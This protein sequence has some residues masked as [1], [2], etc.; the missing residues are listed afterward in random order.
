MA[1]GTSKGD[2]SESLQ[3]TGQQ[4]GSIAQDAYGLFKEARD[5]KS[6]ENNNTDLHKEAPSQEEPPLDNSNVG[7]NNP[8]DNQPSPQSDFNSFR[9]QNDPSGANAGNHNPLGNNTNTG[10]SSGVNSFGR[11]QPPQS[12][13]AAIGANTA[14]AAADSSANGIAG[15]GAQAAKEGVN[16]GVNAAAQASEAAATAG[17]AGAAATSE[18]AAGAAGG[19]VGLVV[20]TAF[21]LRKP[22]FKGLC[23][24]LVIFL[25]IIATIIMGL[26]TVVTEAMLGINGKKPREYQ[27]SD[28]TEEIN[29]YYGEVANKLIDKLNKK[30]DQAISEISASL[31]SYGISVAPAT[32]SA[33]LADS[34]SNP[35]NVGENTRVIISDGSMYTNS[36]YDA[37][38]I[39][40]C[41]SASLQNY[42]YEYESQDDDDIDENFFEWLFN[43]N[44]EKEG[45]HYKDMLR[46]IGKNNI[47]V[48]PISGPQIYTQTYT[49]TVQKE[50]SENVQVS[51]T[52]YSAAR[53]SY[54]EYRAVQKKVYV[55]DS[56]YR[57]KTYY[58]KT[59]NII[60]VPQGSKHWVPNYYQASSFYEA[61]QGPNGKYWKVLADVSGLYEQGSGGRWVDGMS[62]S[63]SVETQTR[64]VE[65]E[66]ERTDTIYKYMINRLDDNAIYQA[67]GISKYQDYG[68]TTYQM[69]EVIADMQQN[70]FDA[71]G[72]VNG[73]FYYSTSTRADISMRIKSKYGVIWFILPSSSKLLDEL[74]DSD[75]PAE[76]KDNFY[77]G[78]YTHFPATVGLDF[79]RNNFIFVDTEYTYTH[80]DTL[81]SASFQAKGKL[82]V[83]YTEKDDSGKDVYK[84]EYWL[85]SEYYT[86]QSNTFISPLYNHGS[87]ASGQVEIRSHFGYRSNS[88]SGGVTSTN[89]G[90]VDL[91]SNGG[92]T[93]GWSVNA[94]ASGTVWACGFNGYG[95]Y[96]V[97]DHGNGYYSLYGHLACETPSGLSSSNSQSS[98]PCVS[99]GQQVLQGQTI[100]YVGS[101]YGSGGYS[102]GP[103]LH[104]EI[105]Q[106]SD[107]FWS[108]KK[109]DPELFVEF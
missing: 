4:M 26:P 8:I 89:H 71:M 108:L 101:T 25:L 56:T 43:S 76:F 73:N 88:F 96:V 17:E 75:K 29:E 36:I 45:T 2:L 68:N 84:T 9:N 92:S 10:N 91:G 103:H 21:A 99:S 20:S 106:G 50:V 42:P 64:I 54:P 97:I 57:L 5:N 83:R 94:T 49:V 105:R 78:A 48:Y 59:G 70:L 90:A 93:F 109:I 40:S 63:I 14:N 12:Q 31:S 52:T 15:A 79:L 100:G 104:F 24:G 82:L 1:E 77:T 53:A 16:G 102:S 6:E 69:Y 47:S 27:G 65:E 44:K 18:A 30:H 95:N 41:Y 35:I 55:N 19:P 33:H 11:Q 107:Y 74:D 28:S 86:S 37:A 7:N 39:M 38:F 3:Q 66:E 98:R 67:F 32:L 81:Q 13:G 60:T 80:K 51:T 62:T 61:S 22:L 23:V 72:G 87:V 34:E 58:Y 46:R 85:S